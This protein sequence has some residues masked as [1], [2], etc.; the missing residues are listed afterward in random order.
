MATNPGSPS[1][2]SS[3]V[4]AHRRSRSDEN[5]QIW[6]AAA[7]KF[8]DRRLEFQPV[9]GLVRFVNPS[10]FLVLGCFIIGLMFMS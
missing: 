10:R 1:H 4:Q 9:P 6:M 8:F 7:I 2:S 3:V 5:L